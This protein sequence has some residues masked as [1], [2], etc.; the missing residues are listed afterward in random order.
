[1]LEFKPQQEM[2]LFCV[3]Y[4]FAWLNRITHVLFM[5]ALPFDIICLI[6]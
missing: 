3:H 5:S 4:C 1:M 2:H 6:S